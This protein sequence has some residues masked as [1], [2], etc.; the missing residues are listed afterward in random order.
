M[1]KTIQPE[2]ATPKFGMRDKLGYM[3]GDFGNDFFFGFAGSY[4]MVFYTD[5]FGISAAWVGIIFMIARI[6]DAFA[7]VAVG[8]FIDLRPASKNGKFK[9]WMMRFAPAVVTLGVLMFTKIPGLSSNFYFIYA[10]VTYILWGT[11]YSGCNIPYGSM[12]SVI[13][14]DS[15]ERASLSTFRT[16]GGMLAGIFTGVLAP[17]LLFKDNQADAGRFFICALTFGIL[18]MICYTLCYYMSIERVSIDNNKSKE[19]VNFATS[20]KNMAKNRAFLAMGANSIVATFATMMVSGLNIYLYKDYFNN[21]KAVSLA[22]LSYIVMILLIGPFNSKLI[23]KFG[24][25]ELAS[26]GVLV[27][28]IIYFLLFLIPNKNVYVF[29]IA[30]YVATCAAGFTMLNGW[31]FITDVVDYHEY[32]TGVREDGTVYSL[33]S[34]VR[35]IAQALVGG[36]TGVALSLAG[37]MEGAASQSE[38]V[39][40][41][42]KNI[43]TLIPAISYMLVFLIIGYWYPLSKKRLEEVSK[44]LELKRNENKA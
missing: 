1:L 29:T 35:K 40:N 11:L 19:K 44:G 30:T 18:A 3:F 42:I 32:M 15:A 16:V 33:F 34:F 7:D 39:A 20:L 25:K 21:A 31:A 22:S 10:V 6:W 26:S 5:V 43:A 13:S 9:P 17:L 12:A 37:Y 4:L 36:L 14:E 28:A 41:N 2:K 38:Q 8:R 23:K 24:K 27:T